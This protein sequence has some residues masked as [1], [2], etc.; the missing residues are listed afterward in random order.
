MKKM[1]ITGATS[2]IGK[3]VVQ[4]AHN[5]N[6]MAVVR[7]GSNKADSLRSMPNVKT[8][9][10]NME[11][12]GT[13][14]KVVG[15][16]DCFVHLAWKGTRGAERMNNELQESNFIHSL[17]AVKSMLDTGCKRIITAGSQ[18]EYGNINGIIT[19][20]VKCHPNTAYGKYKLELYKTASLICKARGI[21]YKEPRIFSIYGSGDYENTL[22]MSLLCKMKNNKPCDLTDG[23]QRWDFLN[24]D[25]AARAILTLCVE[26]CP[27]G[28]YNLASG[29][30]RT[31]REYVEELKEILKSTSE[32]RFGTV[33][34]PSTG[35]VSI[36][37]DIA[38]ICKE[39][40]WKATLD[41][42]AGVMQ[43]MTK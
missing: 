14:G 25:D 22:I 41:F 19:E 4:T 9:E 26:N 17:N 18:A 32:L 10:L 34:Y 2:L 30:I 35:M 33:P 38:K 31:L 39:T 16:A 5:W 20:E 11:E 43:M 8:L 37:P 24:V 13:I 3:A 36:E 40:S 21:E 1:V 23:I 42:K 7:R 15:K 12:Y 27:D 28:A 6:V 29:D